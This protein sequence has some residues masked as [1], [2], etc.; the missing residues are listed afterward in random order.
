MSWLDENHAVALT[1]VV[2]VRSGLSSFWVILKVVQPTRVKQVRNSGIKFFMVLT[3]NNE[4]KH[5]SC[6]VY[7][8]L[9]LHTKNRFQ[10]VTLLISNAFTRTPAKRGRCVFLSSLRLAQQVACSMAILSNRLKD[11][12]FSKYFLLR[13]EIIERLP[14]IA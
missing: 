5:L 14:D 9:L 6:Q 3:K 4:I 2:T 1:S 12:G 13:A 10:R 11:F 8:L 7:N